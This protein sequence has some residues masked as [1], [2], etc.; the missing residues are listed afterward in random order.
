MKLAALAI[1]ASL[2]A[3]HR[4]QADTEC[5]HPGLRARSDVLPEPH[6]WVFNG[7][8]GQFPGG[9]FTSR[10]RAELWIR[11]HRLT[12]VLT[13]Y[14]L[15]EG[16]FDWALRVG[17][18]TGRARTR[19]DEPAFVGTFSSAGQEHYHYYDGATGQESAE[20]VS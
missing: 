14:P 19:G 3:E 7:V 5:S 10:E 15:D 4:H 1:V 2:A 20:P 12:G 16:A 17:A 11:R 13:A 6:V 18:V 8:G 9:V